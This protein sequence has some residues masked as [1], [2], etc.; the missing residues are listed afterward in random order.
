MVTAAYMCSWCRYH[1]V[2]MDREKGNISEF[3][4]QAIIDGEVDG[5]VRVQMLKKIRKH[6]VLRE[7]LE[8]LFFQKQILKEWWEARP[9]E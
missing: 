6:P 2:Q 1:G 3:D 5:E 9:P 4:L 8:T 7:R